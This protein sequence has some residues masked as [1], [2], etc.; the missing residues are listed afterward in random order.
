MGARARTR[1]GPGRCVG[2]VVIPWIAAAIVGATAVGAAPCQPRIPRR[3]ATLLRPVVEGLVIVQASWATDAAQDVLAHSLFETRFYA[4]LDD[5]SPEP[6]EALVALRAYYVGE[7]NAEELDCELMI[8]GRRL[9]PLLERY[10]RCPPVAGRGPFPRNLQ[11]VMPDDDYIETI[12]AI[13][14]GEPCER[15]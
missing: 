15:E 4:L 5:K 14:R 13:R 7:D 9:L 11:T 6:D 3:V 10:Q 2:S 12:A 1:R 8:R